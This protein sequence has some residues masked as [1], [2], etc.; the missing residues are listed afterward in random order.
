MAVF[1]FRRSCLYTFVLPKQ[2]ALAAAWD[3]SYCE[4]SCDELAF[5]YSMSDRFRIKSQP[6]MVPPHCDDPAALD[7]SEI[8]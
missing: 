2:L 8:L 7:V 4:L 3:S 6:L 1:A 5:L